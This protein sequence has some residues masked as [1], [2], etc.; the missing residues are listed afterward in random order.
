MFFLNSPLIAI[1]IGTSAIKVLE[2]GGNQNKRRLL[3]MG[4]ELLPRGVV[5]DGEIRDPATVVKT[6]QTLLQRL[7]IKTKNRRVSLAV[8]GNAVIVKRINIVLD[9]EIEIGEQLFE[10]AKQQFHHDMEDMYFRFQVIESEYK[11]ADETSALIVAAKIAVIEQYVQVVHELGMKVGV[12]DCDS[13][14]I[15]NMF[16]FNYPIADALCAIVDIGASTSQIIVSYNGEFLFNREIYMGGDMVTQ[17]I[18]ESLDVDFENAESIKLSASG[19]DATL[20]EQVRPAIADVIAMITNE[21]QATIS[22]F[23]DGEEFPA[24]LKKI[25]YVYL[26]GGGANTLDLAQ[27]ISTLVQAPVQILNPFHNIDTDNF[28]SDMETML[29]QA[30]LYGVVLGLGLRKM[31]DDQ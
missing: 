4:I 7:A 8:S 22:F 30:P 18:A 29:S 23:L 13:L 9:T 3:S 16:E 11:K 20:M 19:G 14:C 2:L 15:S 21:V 12:I 6:I 10:E 25:S 24:E 27:A 31:N 17:R 1:D 26:T 5:Q 28:G